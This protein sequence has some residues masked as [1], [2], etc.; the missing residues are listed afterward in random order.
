MK[1][2]TSYLDL[3]V[4][5]IYNS[6]Y[7]GPNNEYAAVNGK[8]TF[9]VIE[10]EPYLKMRVL[11]DK[12]GSVY[13]NDLS[14]KVTTTRPDITFAECDLF[15]T[16][17]KSQW[18]KKSAKVTSI[19]KAL[20]ANLITLN[21]IHGRMIPEREISQIINGNNRFK[22]FYFCIEV[23]GTKDNP[24]LQRV[25]LVWKKREEM[26]A[27]LATYNASISRH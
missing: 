14:V 27:E 8:Q 22:G 3:Q 9:K 4:G 21:H 11:F 5:N 1:K 10:L 20:E 19:A 23:Q 15:E 18:F 7:T 25:I 12:Q 26:S 6:V 24:Y 16:E 17:D 2:L 13:R